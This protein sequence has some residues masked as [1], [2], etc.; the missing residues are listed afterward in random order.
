MSNPFFMRWVRAKWPADIGP[1]CVKFEGVPD[2]RPKRWCDPR[3]RWQWP[4]RALKVSRAWCPYHVFFESRGVCMRTMWT[5]DTR[6]FTVRVG[7][8]PVFFSAVDVDGKF[9][10]IEKVGDEYFTPI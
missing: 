4:R 8:D 9:L 2:L 1:Y 3:W 7:P 5:I 10:R 6:G